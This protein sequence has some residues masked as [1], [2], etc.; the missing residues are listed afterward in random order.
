MLNLLITDV[1]PIQ[2]AKD[3]DDHRV[4][5]GLL[6]ATQILC[7]SAYILGMWNRAMYRARN[8]NDPTVVWTCRS[9]N[10]FTWVYHYAYALGDE[11]KIRMGKVGTTHGSQL[12]ADICWETFK[13]H[14][15]KQMYKKVLTPFVN[16]TPYSGIDAISA[17]QRLLCEKKF[18]GTSKWSNREK[19]GWYKPPSFYE[20]QTL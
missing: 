12:V 9:K 13:A 18:D 17:F 15:D 2:A 14:P 1:N 6:D 16:Y 4:A 5:K 10:N 19:P 7:T 11:W 8:E 3:L 20:N